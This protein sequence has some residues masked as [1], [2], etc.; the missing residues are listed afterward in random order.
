[1]LPSRI[2][3]PKR[4]AL[5][6]IPILWKVKMFRGE[7]GNGLMLRTSLVFLFEL[8]IW[9]LLSGGMGLVSFF[10]FFLL[11]FLY[12]CFLRRWST[13][14]YDRIFGR[15]H[16]LDR[17]FGMDRLTVEIFGFVVRGIVWRRWISIP[18]VGNWHA[19]HLRLA[20]NGYTMEKD[21]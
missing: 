9:T 13:L 3:V 14:H 18:G 21:Q 8:F 12:T 11:V 15:E 10:F 2:V 17:P 4:L 20:N 1:M 16:F 19:R 6:Q 5:D 7:G